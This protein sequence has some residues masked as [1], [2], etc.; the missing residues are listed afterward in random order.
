MFEGATKAF[1]AR[2][3]AYNYASIDMC[4]DMSTNT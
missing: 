2:L 3:Y 4:L 1:Q